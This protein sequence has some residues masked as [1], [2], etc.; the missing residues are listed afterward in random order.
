MSDFF[1]SARDRAN[2]LA[3]SAEY[4]NWPQ[5]AEKL[6]KEGYGPRA[7]STL[8]RDRDFKRALDTV[9][10][11]AVTQREQTAAAAKAAMKFSPAVSPW[12]L[13]RKL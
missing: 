7:I 5:I 12:A 11:V 9:I 3:A 6:A 2:A 13:G 8:G 1:A 10:L 4:A